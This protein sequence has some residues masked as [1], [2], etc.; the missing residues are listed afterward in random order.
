MITKILGCLLILAPFIAILI[1]AIKLDGLKDGL[2]AFLFSIATTALV[3][4]AVI[5]GVMLLSE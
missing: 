2:R 4:I 1:V 3:L 5:A